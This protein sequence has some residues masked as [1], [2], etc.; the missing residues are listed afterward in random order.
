MNDIMNSM[1][2]NSLERFLIITDQE[3]QTGATQAGG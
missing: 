2:E 3:M 1:K